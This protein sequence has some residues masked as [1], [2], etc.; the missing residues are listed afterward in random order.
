[1]Q[2]K[3][4]WKDLTGR[5][6]TNNDMS[7]EQVLDIAIEVDSDLDEEEIDDGEGLGY[8]AHHAEEGD[9]WSNAE[10]KFTCI[11]S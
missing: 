5:G 8:W 11:Q 2:K 3:F 10:H 6:Y 1:M 9:E 4:F 7:L